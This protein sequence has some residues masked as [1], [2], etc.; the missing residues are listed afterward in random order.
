MMDISLVIVVSKEALQGSNT[1]P[2]DVKLKALIREGKAFVDFIYGGIPNIEQPRVIATKA[3]RHGM[4]DFNLLARVVDY[5]IDCPNVLSESTLY[6]AWL[7]GDFDG[8][9][10]LICGKY[11]V[12]YTGHINY[13]LC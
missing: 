4:Q 13:S 9:S 8:T 10:K 12:E 3:I 11:S 6:T 7:N 2:S 5:T 1:F